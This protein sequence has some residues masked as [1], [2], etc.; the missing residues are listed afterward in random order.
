MLS[1]DCRGWNRACVLVVRG[2]GTDHRRRRRRRI[3]PSI[4][5]AM[6]SAGDG[7]VPASHF[8][9]RGVRRVTPWQTD[10]RLRQR[11]P[12]R[13][14][15]SS[16]ASRA[17]RPARGGARRASA[18][19]STG[20]TTL[21]AVD[22]PARTSSVWTRPATSTGSSSSVPP[23]VASSMPTLVVRGRGRPHSGRSERCSTPSRRSTPASVTW[24]SP[25]S[26]RRASRR[27]RSRDGFCLFNGVAVAAAKLGGG[28]RVAIVDWDV[29]HG[30]GTQALLRRRPRAVR[31]DA[32]VAPLPGDGEDHETGGPT[33]RGRTAPAVPGRH[34]V[35]C[36]R[37][38]RTCRPIVESLRP[39]W[40]SSLRAS[41]PIATIRSPASNSPRRLRRPR[42]APAVAVPARGTVVFGRR[43]RLRRALM[44]TG[45]VRGDDRRARSTRIGIARR[46]RLPTI[47]VAKQ[48]R[49]WRVQ[50]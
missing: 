49:D 47:V 48:Q 4:P 41:T 17:A 25:P 45:A 3:R 20:H 26:R 34:A 40:C 30:N 11:R 43:L 42:G 39:D 8:C 13:A 50:P 33:H 38:R 9:R 10:P 46:D 32:R 28:D 37:L 1:L 14:S 2:E 12:R 15:H 5:T 36:R 16:V 21:S 24:P 6:V 27:G 7:I 19:A 23:A 18:G 35:T 29:H 22:R 31:L 44:S